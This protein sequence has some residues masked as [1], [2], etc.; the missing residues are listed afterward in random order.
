MTTYTVTA[1]NWATDSENKIH[2]D[3]VAR[4][5]GFAGG[6]VPGVTLFAYLARP[7]AEEW[8]RDWLAGGRADVRFVSPVYDGETV[9]AA[10]TDGSALAL[11]NRAGETCAGGTVELSRGS[12][13]FP[14]D[15]PAAALPA[16]RPSAGAGSLAPGTVLGSVDHRHDAETAADY[17]DQVGD[18][19]PLFR[20]EGYAH[21]GWLLSAAN[22]VLVANV[23]LGPWMHVESRV[24]FLRPVSHGQT[25]QTRARVAGLSERKGHRFVDLDVVVLADGDRAMAVRHVAIYE[26]RQATG[27]A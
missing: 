5:F 6:L 1:R 10:F 21:P 20:Q 8:G 13:L 11:R 19:L 18:D 9:T 16:R 12:P 27:N 24:Q 4:R 23:V 17:L 7:V 26:P 2:D 3:A 22:D 14:L 15:V 25:L